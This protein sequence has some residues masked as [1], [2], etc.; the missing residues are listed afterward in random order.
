MLLR[1]RREYAEMVPEFYDIANSERSEDEIGALRQVRRES[2]EQGLG[3]TGTAQGS[4]AGFVA[5]PPREQCGDVAS[6]LA[7]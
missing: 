3:G 4:G 7:W 2:R 6:T 1:K 5:S